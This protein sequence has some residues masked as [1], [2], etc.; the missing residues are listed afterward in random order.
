MN[1]PLRLGPGRLSLRVRL[2][3]IVTGL[4]AVGLVA[5]SGVVLG[6][7][8]TW[9]V[10]RVDAQLETLSAPLSRIPD[11]VLDESG[12]QLPRLPRQTSGLDLIHEVDVVYLTPDGGVAH[13][14]RLYSADES[15]PAVPHL[16]AASVDRLADRPFTV[17]SKRGDD[18]WRVLVASRTPS[19]GFE[20][21]LAGVS[22][23][24]VSGGAVVVGAELGDVDSTVGAVRAVCL[25]TGIATLAL[26]VLVGWFAVGAG[27]RPLRR[28]E[29]TAAA[30]AAGDLSHRV[31]ALASPGTEVGRLALALNEMLARNE[32]AFASLASSEDRMRRFVA[33]ASHELRTPLFGIRGFVQLYLMGGL[34]EKADVDRGMARIDQESARLVRLVED[35]LLLTRLDEG[36][37]AAGSARPD[38]GAGGMGRAPRPAP[39]DL[40]AL[41]ADARYDLSTLDPERSVRLTGPGGDG[42]AGAAAVVADEAWLRQV[43]TNIVGNVI[44]HTPAGGPVRIGVGAVGGEAILEIADS[45]PGLHAEQARRVFD[46]FYRTDPA[47][48]RRSA[49]EPETAGPEPEPDTG[50]AS[51]GTAP[52]GPAAGDPASGDPASGGPEPGA[53]PGSADSGPGTASGS[54]LGLAIVWSLMAASGGRVELD[55]APEAGA[56]F[57]L[58]LPERTG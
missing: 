5:S 1:R 33:D 45:G 40:R 58:V 20:G 37:E 6:S 11:S 10:N 9:L 18:A 23:G 13:E 51:D 34:P 27:L 52:D 32:R 41:A 56:T 7:L 47:R 36:P 38:E 17:P 42:P 14:F 19:A 48:G 15:G 46:R 2:L 57:R 8:R 49:S 39:M 24:A 25:A 55:T 21:G 31:P 12:D 44:A 28:V 50:P 29:R 22:G 43:V 35:L 54:G 30:I 3:L 16:D 26:L 4:F 53:G